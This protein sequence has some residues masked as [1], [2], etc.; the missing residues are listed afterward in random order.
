[1]N[2]CDAHRVFFHL[3]GW[4][5]WLFLRIGSML[6]R[7]FI[8]GAQKH[9]VDVWIL[10]KGANP[11]TSCEKEIPIVSSLSRCALFMPRVVV[12]IFKWLNEYHVWITLEHKCI[13]CT[14]KSAA[15]SIPLF[16]SQSK[17]LS[18]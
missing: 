12:K 13:I 2:H 15:T 18:T 14:G 7:A 6:E 10:T 17:H 11:L 8:C 16:I 9:P 3:D 5:T 4:C 1:M